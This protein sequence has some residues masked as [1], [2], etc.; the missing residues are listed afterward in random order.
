MN[1]NKLDRLS[2]LLDGLAPVVTLGLSSQERLQGAQYPDND[3][4]LQLWFLTCGSAELEIGD[5]S[6]KVESPALVA[7]HASQSFVLH[8]FSASDP[9]RLIRAHVQLTGPVATLFLEEFAQPRTV[10][11]ADDEPALRLAVAMIESE[12]NAPRCG[13]PALLNRAGDILFIGLLRYLVAH[14]VAKEGGLFNGLADPRIAKALVAMH[15][16]PAFGWDLELLA[17]EAGMSRTAFANRFHETM[18]RPPG[19]Y[20]AAV[21]LAIAQRAVD[22]GKGLKEAARLAGYENSS[23]LS[24]ALSK[25]RLQ[26]AYNG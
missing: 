11:L 6:L 12:L 13:H 2:A 10:S 7:V 4:A 14:P 9:N 3:S 20:L 23:A 18:R 15:Q 25:S 1:D 24:R 8:N 19:K 5:S 26:A 22:L 17:H 16:R 21:R